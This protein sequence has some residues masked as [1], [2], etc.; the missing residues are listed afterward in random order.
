MKKMIWMAALLAGFGLCAETL[1]PAGILG[2]SGAP[3]APVT[4]GTASGAGLVFDN[5]EG[6]YYCRTGLSELS[7]LGED[8][9]VLARYALPNIHTVQDAM[10]RCGDRIVFLLGGQ[11]LYFLKLNAPA[12]TAAARYPRHGIRQPVVLSVSAFGG[13]LAVVE[14]DGNIVRFDPESGAAEAWG[15]L[16]GVRIRSC[17][18]TPEGDLLL[19]E[20]DGKSVRLLKSAAQSPE[21]P[22]KIIGDRENGAESLRRAGNFYYCG[23]SGGTLRRFDLALNPAPGVILGGQS[24]HFIGAVKT[25]YEVDRM[26]GIVET[27]PG[28]LV[29]SGFSGVIF[30]G[31]FDASTQKLVLRKRFGTIPTCAALEVDATGRVFAGNKLWNWNDAPD[32]PVAISYR[33]ALLTPI[34]AGGDG[35]FAAPGAHPWN[36]PAV[37]VGKI[38]ENEFRF[39]VSKEIG[40]P[41]NPIGAARFGNRLLVVDATG[42]TTAIEFDPAHKNQVWKKNLGPVEFTLKSPGKSWSAFRN[43]GDRLFAAID[44]AIVEFEVDGNNWREK[45]RWNDNFGTELTFSIDGNRILVGDRKGNRVALYT[46]DTH[47]KLAEAAAA[48]PGAVALNGKYAAV[49]ESGNQRVLKLAVEE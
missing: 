42:K 25:D 37:Y 2:N 40:F 22:R 23:S 45:S 26:N 3:D 5:D 12:G 11:Q 16:P 47:K 1:R 18:F 38:G 39:Q 49:Y 20:G 31:D 24:G 15:A 17:D 10:A 36:Q 29:F 32:A 41:A 44:G 35:T 9:K 6:I 8:G 13:K 4:F 7:A 27:R 30:R 21:A 28:E 14:K 43:A 19:M 46:L 48:A 33:D 34:A